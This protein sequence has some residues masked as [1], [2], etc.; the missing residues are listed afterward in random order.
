MSQ[1][2]PPVAELCRSILIA[3]DNQGVREALVTILRAQGYDVR[4]AR[5]GREALVELEKMPA[6]ALIFLDL[7]MPIMNGWEFLDSWTKNSSSSRAHKV[8]TI[9][10]VN[11]KQ[12]W[13]APVPA[14]T[15][16][17]LQKP[18]SFQHVLNY[19]MR[20]CQRPGDIAAGENAMT[21]SKAGS[22]PVR[23]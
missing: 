6:P 1:L 21:P 17:A 4:G 16:G 2:S 9:S 23:L 13:D 11:P 7:M 3:D 20:Y 8:V 10:A 14:N 5:N 12:K 15:V 19:V 22:A 18:L